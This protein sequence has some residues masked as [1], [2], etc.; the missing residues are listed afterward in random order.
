MLV[1]T[2]LPP[3]PTH[4]IEPLVAKKQYQIVLAYGA[5]Y[6]QNICLIV[7]S[8]WS[9]LHKLKDLHQINYT[10]FQLK[11]LSSISHHGAE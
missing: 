9:L 6:N 7:C 10:W 3:Q 5:A 11:M 2:F 1:P 4:A 8:P